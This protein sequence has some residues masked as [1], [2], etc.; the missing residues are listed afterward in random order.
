MHAGADVKTNGLRDAYTNG[1]K[2]A[3]LR[4]SRSSSLLSLCC[5]GRKGEMI[6]LSLA[7]PLQENTDTFARPKSFAASFQQHWGE[8]FTVG[9]LL[10]LATSGEATQ[11]CWHLFINMKDY[12]LGFCSV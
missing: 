10:L 12:T 2:T 9:N 5:P 7:R 4:E 8:I 11:I 3:L 1:V 6:S